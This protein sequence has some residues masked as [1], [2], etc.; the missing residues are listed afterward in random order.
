MTT[1][2]GHR[3]AAEELLMVPRWVRPGQARALLRAYQE[4]ALVAAGLSEAM[5]R[6]GLVDQG[7]MA[8]PTVDD[9]GEPV[10]WLRLTV[11]GLRQLV[12]LL[13]AGSG[14]PLNRCEHRGQR[15][16]LRCGCG[17]QHQRQRMPAGWRRGEG[18]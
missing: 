3:L 10:V 12:W 13:T 18:V 9:A 7:C 6:A 8:Q 5:R 17:D 2:E 14:P 1:D 4:A 15:A 16:A 11:A